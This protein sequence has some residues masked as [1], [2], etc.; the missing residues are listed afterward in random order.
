MPRAS[1]RCPAGG[2]RTAQGGAGEELRAP[3]SQQH[4][5]AGAAGPS[6]PGL[7]LV[8]VLLFLAPFTWL[9]L[10]SCSLSAAKRS[11][12]LEPLAPLV[13]RA[14]G[15]LVSH[16]CP[17]LA[18]RQQRGWSLCCPPGC[19]SK[20]AELRALAGGSCGREGTFPTN[21]LRERIPDPVPSAP[22]NPKSVTVS[23][24]SFLGVVDPGGGG[25]RGERRGGQEGRL[26][27]FPGGLCLMSARPRS[28]CLR[29][30]GWG[31]SGSRRGLSSR[32]SWPR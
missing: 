26:L 13:P 11:C 15:V 12:A 19:C 24:F 23:P 25:W 8:W 18:G 1:A 4:E 2:P 31:C 14:L 22:L 17:L 20:Q 27:K 5:G 7:A 28:G 21:V 32:A 30:A 10:E 3:G 6:P 29:E 9:R 16:G